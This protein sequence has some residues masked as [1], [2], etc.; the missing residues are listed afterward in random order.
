MKNCKKYPKIQEEKKKREELEKKLAELREQ[1]K[2]QQS[3]TGGVK[4]V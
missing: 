3:N 2:N 1:N 4:S